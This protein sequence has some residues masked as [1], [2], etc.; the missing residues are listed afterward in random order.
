MTPEE[1][2]RFFD[3]AE[4]EWAHAL[5]PHLPRRALIAGLVGRVLAH[6]SAER[7]LAPL[8]IGPG[9]EGK[10]M[11]LRQTVVDCLAADP[12]LRVL[13]RADKRPPSTRRRLP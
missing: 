2:G 8:L 10:T 5:C 3:G 12:N 13:W 6:R 11:A 4:P 9:G 1:A 7:R